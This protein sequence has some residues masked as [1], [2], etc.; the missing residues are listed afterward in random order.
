M[1]DEGF[2]AMSKHLAVF[3]SINHTYSNVLDQ[4]TASPS[5]N[6]QT[7]K[8]CYVAQFFCSISIITRSRSFNF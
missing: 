3:F 4:S 7:T 1:D 6:G 2:F 8:S 5:L